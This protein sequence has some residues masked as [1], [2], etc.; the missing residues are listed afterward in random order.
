MS[1]APIPDDDGDRL[2]SLQRMNVLSA[3]READID[4]IVRITRKVFKAD[5]ALIALVDEKDEL[6]LSCDGLDLTEVPREVSISAY[7][8]QQDDVFVVAD[9]SQ[10]SRFRAHPLVAD[11]P[12]IKFY[13]GKPLTNNEGFRIGVLCF[14]STK[15]RIFSPEE[16]DILH[17]LG[18]MV[19]VVLENRDLN[20]TQAALIHSMAAAERCQLIDAKSGLWNKRGLDELFLR[21]IARAS[22]QNLPMA[23][24]LLA[25]DHGPSFPLALED[26][27]GAAAVR[28]TAQLLQDVLRTTDVVARYSDEIFAL[29]LPGI[30]PVMVPAIGEK[31]MR[32]F[33]SKGKVGV[34]GGAFNLV[35]S[36]GFTVAFP[37]RSADINAGSLVEAAAAALQKA[38]H[39]GGDRY[40]ISGV[41]N[42]LLA[43]LALA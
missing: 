24:A 33:R 7:A 42:S 1:Q 38:R 34:P 8:I 25:I 43:S 14:V 18:R 13:A 36:L 17:D 15:T 21:E 23:V 40:E 4:R 2:A 37:R 12:K 28:L 35:V 9:A 20:D 6:L 30:Y 29:I 31:V 27:I 10:D 22:R 39:D 19:E 16:A 3:P 26:L 11:G 5:S 32:A 41:S